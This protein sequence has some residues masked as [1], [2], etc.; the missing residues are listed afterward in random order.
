MTLPHAAAGALVGLCVAWAA[1]AHIVTEAPWHPIAYAYRSAV[2]LINLQPTDWELIER[3]LTTDDGR[4]ADR[5]AAERIRELDQETG[6][7]HWPA[8]EQALA[9]R[10][11]SALYAAST[12]AVAHAIRHQLE[13][14][15]ARLEHPGEAR[16]ELDEAER[17]YRGFAD[18]IRESD[19]EG[20][21]ELGLAWLDLS[22]RIATVNAA[23]GGGADPTFA[24]ARATIDDYLRANY[25]PDDFAPR[26][27]FAPI[28][29]QR[30]RADPS[31]RVTPWLPPGS[32]LND[33]DP[34]PRLVLNFEEQGIDERD[35]FLVAFGDMLFD[36]P[37]IFGEPAKGLGLACSTCHNRSDINQRLFIPGITPK[38]GVIDVDGAFFNARF[39]DHRPDAIDIPSL[40]GIRFTAPYGRDG[41][42]ASL[43]DFTRNVIVNEFGGNE[44][45]PLMLD[46]LVAYM[47]EF[48]FLPAPYLE[49]DG[50]L[51]A[52]ASEAARRGE[53]LFN[54]P[55]EQMAGRSCASCHIPDSFFTDN[56]GHN[57]GSGGESYVG[58]LDGAYD[59]PTLLNIV[60]TAPYFHDGSLE[61]LEAVV[62]WFDDRFGLGLSARE[63]DDLSAYLEAVG[64]GAAPY[65]Q[66]DA[67]N[68]PF[69]LMA[70]E[71]STF[72][73]TL[74][75]LIPARDREHA[76]LVLRT[77]A[78]D[79][80]ADASAMSNRA[81]IEQVHE[82]VARLEQLREAV[83]AGQWAEAAALWAAYQDLERQ[84]A[85]EMY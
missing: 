40:R 50:T 59:T 20:Y 68:T 65:E 19:P 6:A 64:T 51:N 22:S 46:A 30:F 82:M 38:P 53:A 5:S 32:D 47:L 7:A 63:Q 52:Q 56:R 35:L 71:L 1:S 10:D 23:A 12:R 67:E 60:H 76:D 69:R 77:V 24:A 26:R 31:L 25:Q 57:I 44:P 42:M 3:K 75:T 83:A 2:F 4:P 49:R 41:R 84:Y 73:S 36:S 48:D 11:A 79:L 39:N 85:M 37:E 43:R 61:S 34:L 8:I 18:F 27:S 55:F 80:A 14:A 28:P 33:Q 9:S 21:R 78:S 29:E 15:A 17:L 62:A 54:R 45:S 66:F 70:Q 74:D 72:L 81:A 58:S 16:R 13:R